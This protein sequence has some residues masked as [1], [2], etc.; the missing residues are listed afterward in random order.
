MS[1]ELPSV[2]GACER[3]RAGDRRTVAK[4]I[5]LLESRRPDQAARGQE[6][7]EKL[8]PYTGG[9]LRLGITGAP[10][11]GKSTFIEALGLRLI[12]KGHRLAVLAVDPTSP[13]SGGS[14]LG[15]K[16]RMERLAQD[17]AAFIRPS[18]SGGSLGGVA[19]RTRETLLLTEAAGFD[20]VLVE[21]VG[22]GQSEVAVHSMVDCFTLLL[23][24][25]A[26]DELQGIKKGVLELADALV[27]TKADGEL[28]RAAERSRAEYAHA[29][30]LLRPA[31]PHWTPRVLAVSAVSGEGVDAFWEMVLAHRS[32]LE[33][34]GALERKR[35]GQ[36]RAWM[37][38][39]VHEGLRAAFDGHPAV[40]R[41]I[42]QAE[43][44][45]EDQKATPAA[46]ARR[47]LEA[48]LDD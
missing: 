1:S 36:A 8:V 25:G 24:P 22:I 11:V 29:L 20:I 42:P 16:T 32:A 41:R 47:L 17:E 12:E 39:L 28:R 19:E 14:I 7:L 46:A 38:S 3:V 2:A 5:T 37:W 45:V 10:G 43:R 44:D 18:P 6:I 4:T 31:S 27:V 21:T 23:Q 9:S 33:A 26:G 13:R 30:E 48:F 34:A 15:D 40:A 35:R